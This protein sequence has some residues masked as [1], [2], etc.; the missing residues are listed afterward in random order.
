M[1]QCTILLS[2]KC[3]IKRYITR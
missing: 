1:L 3:W 2:K